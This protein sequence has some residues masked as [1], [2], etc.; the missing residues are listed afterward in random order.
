MKNIDNESR[1]L[2][3]LAVFRE[4]YDSKKE[5]Y[6]IIAEFIKEIICVL[7]TDNVLNLVVCLSTV[8]LYN[9]ELFGN[10][11]RFDLRVTRAL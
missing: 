11:E 8:L 5:V 1:L 10:T 3:S 6:G 9:A 4:L 7:S 2:A